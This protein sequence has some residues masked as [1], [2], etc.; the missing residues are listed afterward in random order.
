MTPEFFP[1]F[2]TIGYDDD[3]MIM[4][5]NLLQHFLEEGVVF[6]EQ[7]L[8]CPLLA[9]APDFLDRALF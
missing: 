2:S 5:Q 7:H 8:H 4:R 3:G 1:C 9:T 6:S